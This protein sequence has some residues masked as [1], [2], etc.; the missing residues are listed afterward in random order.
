MKFYEVFDKREYGEQPAR[1]SK[2]G[3]LVMITERESK[4][5][6]GDFIAIYK[7]NIIGDCGT[8]TGFEFLVMPNG[9]SLS[10][11]VCDYDTGEKV[12]SDNLHGLL[13]GEMSGAQ[14]D[15][16]LHSLFVEYSK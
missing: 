15:M 13:S 2:T 3:E 10:T 9:Y 1:E 7:S 8:E 16:I 5:Q 11:Y 6:I 14:L 12:I 4:I